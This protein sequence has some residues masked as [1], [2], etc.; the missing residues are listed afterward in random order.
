MW[1]S[2]FSASGLTFSVPP[3]GQ[4]SVLSPMF[5]PKLTSRGFCKVSQLLQLVFKLRLDLDLIASSWCGGV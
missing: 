3:Q 4:F 2:A 5:P 1:L